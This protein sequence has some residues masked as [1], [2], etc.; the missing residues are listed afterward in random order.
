MEDMQFY[1]AQQKESREGSLAGVGGLLR[2]QENR[3]QLREKRRIEKEEYLKERREK[4]LEK[5]K[6]IGNITYYFLIVHYGCFF[7]N[8]TLISQIIQTKRF[9]YTNSKNRMNQSLQLVIAHP[10]QEAGVMS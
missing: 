3:V 7:V 1:T 5:R 4:D 8:I 10:K 9:Y 6:K 2:Q